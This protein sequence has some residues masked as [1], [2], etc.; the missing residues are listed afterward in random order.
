MNIEFKKLTLYINF[1]HF[2]CS[3]SQ[4]ISHETGKKETKKYV[5]FMKKKSLKNL[6]THTNSLRFAVQNMFSKL[7]WNASRQ[8]FF[9]KLAQSGQLNCR[10]LKIIAFCECSA[11]AFIYGHLISQKNNRLMSI[12]LSSFCDA[13]VC[14][15][16]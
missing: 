5:L 1:Y 11:T 8:E 2:W 15:N 16:S 13:S 12:R 6:E 14:I 7:T 4:S 10:N 9:P 3:R